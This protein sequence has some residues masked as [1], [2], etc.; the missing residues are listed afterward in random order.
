MVVMLFGRPTNSNWF[1]CSSIAWH[2]VLQ[3]LA[4]VVGH[5]QYGGAIGLERLQVF[6]ALA[7]EE[8]IAHC[9][10]F[11]HHQNIRLN[12]G[13]HS[14]SQSQR[15]AAGV[16]LHRLMNKVPDVGKARMASGRHLARLAQAQQRRI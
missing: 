15:H 13:L 12:V 2:A 8:F 4:T 11:I 6:K 3:D 7:L 5:Q 9:E 14:K 10:R 16:G 1:L